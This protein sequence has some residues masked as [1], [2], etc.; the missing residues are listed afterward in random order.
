MAGQSGPGKG[1]ARHGLHGRPAYEPWMEQ[2]GIPIHEGST[3]V[4]DIT[5][6]PRR[7][8]ARL[9]GSGTFINLEGTK[10]AGKL[11]YIAEIPAGGALAPD[12]HLY[13]E[14]IYILRGRGLSEV[15]YAGQSKVSFEWGEGS[16]FAVPLNAWHRLVNGGR[17][18]VLFF[19]VTNIPYV[20]DAFRNS[21]FIFNCDYKFIDRFTGR[22]DYFL[23]GEK[24]Y[25]ERVENIWETNFVPDVRQT[26]LDDMSLKV[27]DGQL[28]Q[29]R[30]ASW[31]G[32]HSSEWPVGKYHKAHCHEPGAVLLG[33]KSEGFV[34]VWPWECGAHPYQD[35]YG[36][37][38][39][40]M[41]WKPNSIYT[42]FTDSGYQEW[43]HQH[44]NTGAGPA[45]HLAVTGGGSSFSARIF[46]KLEE[47]FFTSVRQVGGRLID[48]E[49]E[50]PE[51]RRMF[52]EAL[53]QRGVESEMAPVVYRTDPFKCPS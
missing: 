25:K 11:L 16:L 20:M 18:P 41:D 1:S 26:F 10:R 49:D 32:V 45:R 24:R 30:L 23:P 9:G 8:W 5:E 42:P 47:P 43:F 39:V 29:F 28:T 17:Q 27:Q 21:E 12:K 36:D 2:E 22:A 46:S 51:I 44:F 50:D 34:L 35:G 14:L 53:R 19:A 33:L 6:L 3:G 4:E 13:D 7:P 40:K 52:E 15:W 48:Y 37:R 38:V 31:T